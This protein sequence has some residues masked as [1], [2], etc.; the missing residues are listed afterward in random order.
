MAWLKRIIKT[1]F[2][3]T[4]LLWVVLHISL[5]DLQNLLQQE[6]WI[7]PTSLVLLFVRAFFQAYRFRILITPFTQSLSALKMFF[8]DLKARYFSIVIPFSMGQDVVRGTMLHSHGMK[9]DEIVAVSLFFRVTGII[10]LMI[11]A[12]IGGFLLSSQQEL[13]Q[14]LTPLVLALVVF[15]V[16]LV[17]LFSEK[18]SL[19]CVGVLPSWIS[20]K[21]IRFLEKTREALH[22]YKTRLSL[23]IANMAVSTLNQIMIVVNSL[24]ILRALTGEWYLLESFAFV[25]IVEIIAILV[26]FA[27]NGAGAREGGYY[28]LFLFLGLQDILADFLLI[29]SFIYVVN[30]SG[31]FVVF[32]EKLVGTKKPSQNEKA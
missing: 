3:V 27:P 10:P 18:V 21:V 12:L 28:P 6:W 1:A 29:N 16:G 32:W 4:P 30:F 7:I 8:V 11:M 24:L 26:P 23:F 2:I 15:V 5:Q 31:I 13:Q 19:W 17:V 14:L 9:S 22:L 25:P 20:P